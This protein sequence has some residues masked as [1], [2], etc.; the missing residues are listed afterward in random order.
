MDI[1]HRNKL[2]VRWSA[3]IGGVITLYWIMFYFRT[4]YVPVENSVKLS[5]VISITLPFGVSRWFDIVAG[6][7]MVATVILLYPKI[8]QIN[9]KLEEYEKGMFSYPKYAANKTVS[10]LDLFIVE[11]AMLCIAGIIMISTTNGSMWVL[12][13]TSW[14]ITSFFVVIVFLGDGGR[15][16]IK[17]RTILVVGF[18]ALL[19]S[20]L[21]IA[22]MTGILNGCIVFAGTLPVFLGLIA[23]CGLLSWFFEIF[24]GFI[25]D[26]TKRF[27]SS[28][29]NWLAGE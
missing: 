1:N 21:S 25:G 13:L 6:V 22:V 28:A 23:V 2:L 4:G 12:L 11:I 17:L 18:S 24:R 19:T 14:I 8:D 15:T 3:V 29:S 16:S 20:S 9:E 7:L 27:Y 26:H 10:G 5:D